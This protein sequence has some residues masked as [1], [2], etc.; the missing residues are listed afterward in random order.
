MIEFVRDREIYGR[1][2]EA[3]RGAERWL[4]IATADLK[5]MQVVEV[6]RARP[7][8]GVLAGLVGRGVEVRLL[9]AK[10]PGENW[11]R[12]FDRYPSL[13]GGMERMLCPRVH[14]KCVVA[15]GRAAYFGSAN[16]TGAGMGAKSGRNRNFENGVWTDEPGLVGAV[17]EQFDA[18][19]RGEFCGECG[20]KAWCGDGPVGEE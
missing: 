12:D 2:V 4:W 13:R 10:E 14:F 17:A 6:G 16:L 18:V 8:L 19:W 3:A 5:D 20:R 15:D 9:H 7:F 1:V 11:R